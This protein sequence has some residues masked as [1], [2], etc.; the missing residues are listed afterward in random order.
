MK[1]LFEN[2]PL[3]VLLICCALA[4]LLLA[5]LFTHSD[6]V[7]MCMMYTPF[8]ATGFLS[9]LYL[10][11]WSSSTWVDV[12]APSFFCAFFALPWLLLAA[13]AILSVMRNRRWCIVGFVLLGIDIVLNTLF[14]V[15]GFWGSAITLSLN[16]ALV[17][18]LFC[19]MNKQRR[20]VYN[21]D[22]VETLT[23]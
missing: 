13:S 14:F 2:K 23:K 3:S 10:G 11:L 1:R 20:I 4:L 5:L 21:Q 17:V 19:T 9:F 22:Q 12:W 8:F 6:W 7:A 16:V 18:L 15:T